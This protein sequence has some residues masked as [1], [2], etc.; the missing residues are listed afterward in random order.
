MHILG[1]ETSC[2]ETAASVV[3][4]GRTILSNIVSSS[5]K[6]HSRYGGIIPEIA[7]RRQMELISAVVQE[8]LKEAGVEAHDLG[9]IAVTQSPGLIGSLLVGVSFARAFSFALGKPL[10]KVDHIKAH[11]YA[12]FLDRQDKNDGVTPHFNS[13]VGKEEK[14]GVT[15]SLP[16]I[17]LVV[18]GGH[19]SLF[20]VKAFDRF[21][22]LGQTRDDA[23]GE[24]YD[25]VAR[26]LGLGYPGGPMIDSLAAKGKN[27]EIRFPCA[28]LE[29]SFDFSF[30]G[31]K[32]A[33]LYHVR[34]AIPDEEKTQKIAYAFQK[35]V[36]SVL[37]DKSIHA[38]RKKRLKTLL[39]GGGVAANS[40]L[41]QQ[42][43]ARATEEEIKVFFPPLS[44]CTDNAAMIAGLGYRMVVRNES[45][46]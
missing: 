45:V 39:V 26:I 2:D 41:R 6:D 35:S 42:L 31:V 4:D 14:W 5:L 36:V 24:A 33:V 13:R 15:P 25:K 20:Q 46:N 17:G 21:V 3:Q 30:S 34:Q 10:V 16:A 27:E 1:I 29:E 37:V 43:K 9:A 18:S 28:R 32:T 11:L 38:C 12:N 8:A 19:S 23:V 40:Y 22:L 44:L 7:S